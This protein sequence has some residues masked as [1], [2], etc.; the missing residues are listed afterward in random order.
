VAVFGPRARRVIPLAPGGRVPAPFTATRRPP[1]LWKVRDALLVMVAGFLF[2][3]T[4]L[5][6]TLGLFEL[7]QGNPH[8]TE[9][10]AAISTLVSTLFFLFLLW[11]MYIVVVKRYRCSW[12]MLG[13]RS[14]AWQWLA[15]VPFV[16]ALLTFSYVL[17]LRGMVAIFGPTVQWPKPLTSTTVA[18]TQQPLLEALVVL[19]G[20]VLTPLA[21]E[22]LFRGVLYQA[23][24]RSMPVGSAAV[25]S[26]LIFAAMHLS[27]VL[28]VPLT[29]MGIVLAIV[30]ERSGS[31]IPT[32]LIHAC[33]N[34]IILL[35]IAGG[36]TT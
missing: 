33:N 21:E 7:Q 19:T 29:L 1:A 26:A 11:M 27:V 9:P 8:A 23:L 36:A 15:A 24:R 17:M 31:I 3:A 13:M 12:R 16:F 35:I 4:A 2:L 30:F 32:I 34:G 22:L 10:R 28:F 20:V 18:A 14:V 25:L 6:T 5:I